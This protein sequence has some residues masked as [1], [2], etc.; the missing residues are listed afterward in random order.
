MTQPKCK[1]HPD[2]PFV[3]RSNLRPSIFVLD[4][5]IRHSQMSSASQTAVVERKRLNGID[6]GN[7]A[8]V[9]PN[10]DARLNVRNFT[11]YSKATRTV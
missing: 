7:V 1:C 5:S 6:I 11:V 2:S 8:G 10:T 9:S 3:W 4:K